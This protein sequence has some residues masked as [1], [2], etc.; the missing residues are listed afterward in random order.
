MEQWILSNIFRNGENAGQIN[1]GEV[2]T[3]QSRFG[4]LRQ[5]IDSSRIDDIP[6]KLSSDWP[7]KVSGIL[8]ICISWIYK[9]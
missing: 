2:L 9:N 1:V 6:R 3:I 7:T 4:K 5:C 8:V